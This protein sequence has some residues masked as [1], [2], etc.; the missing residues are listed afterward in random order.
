MP[1]P[2]TEHKETLLLMGLGGESVVKRQTGFV[3]KLNRK[4]PKDAQIH[5]FDT[6]WQTEETDEDKYSRLISFVDKHSFKLVYA[7]SAGGSL[8]MRLVPIMPL[9]TEYHFI[10]AK[11]QYPET[12]GSERTTR[13][14]ALKES[15]AKSQEIIQ[16]KEL[17]LYNITCHAGFLDGI[18]LQSDKRIDTVPFKRIPMINHSAAIVLAYYTILRKL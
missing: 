10:S 13:A 11:L 2:N 8:G 3:N 6:R 14:P 12:I 1:R 5:I 9:S 17:S 4:R 18:L 15:V 7:I 16:T